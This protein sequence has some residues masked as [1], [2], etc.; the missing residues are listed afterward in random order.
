[1]S[2]QILN[3][4]ITLLNEN[5]ADFRVVNHEPAA[6]SEASAKARGTLIGQGAKALVCVIKGVVNPQISTTSKESSKADQ[7]YPSSSLK[8]T[9]HYV[10]AVLPADYKANLEAITCEF[11]GTKTS[12]ASPAEV[13]ELTDC[14]IGSVPPFS[15]HERLELIV[16]SRLFKRFDEIAFNAG[17]LDRSIILSTKDYKRIVKPRIVNFASKE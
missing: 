3:K 13:S 2:E 7:A 8:N 11:D 5:K 9:K 16:D 10:L 4:I 17:L 6:T 14:V 12:L 1:M 15:F